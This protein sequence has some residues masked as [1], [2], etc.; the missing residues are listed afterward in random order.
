MLFFRKKKPAQ[1]QFVSVQ[2]TS[3]P[4]KETVTYTKQTQTTHTSNE[5]DGMQ[6]RFLCDTISYSVTIIL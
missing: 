5:R 1:L 6:Y 3:I 4:P 2:S